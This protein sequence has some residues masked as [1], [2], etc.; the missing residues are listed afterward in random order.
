MN[1]SNLVSASICNLSHPRSSQSRRRLGFARPDNTDHVVRDQVPVKDPSIAMGIDYC[2]PKSIFILKASCL[3]ALKLPSKKTQLQLS[4]TLYQAGSLPAVDAWFCP[5]GPHDKVHQSFMRPDLSVEWKVQPLWWVI[6]RNTAGSKQ[7]DVWQMLEK[8]YPSGD[9]SLRGTVGVACCSTTFSAMPCAPCM[10]VCI[11]SPCLD[12]RIG[13]IVH[14]GSISSVYRRLAVL[15]CGGGFAVARLLV[16]V[17]DPM[18]SIVTPR[19]TGR[20]NGSGLAGQLD[21][22]AMERVWFI[23]V[24][25]ALS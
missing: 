21:I 18:R 6:P 8:G 20:K 9:R 1:T 16:L 12:G 22:M 10:L 7:H 23:C 25:V 5:A 11:A 15:F 13:N 24:L 17:L 2:T 14:D 19:G 4:G 3:L